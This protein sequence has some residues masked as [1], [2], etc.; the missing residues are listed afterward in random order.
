[1][2]SRDDFLQK[3]K[4]IIAKRAG[5]R[6]SN[7]TCHHITIGANSNPEKSTN[8]GV[9]SHI[10]AAA[11]GGPRYNPILTPVERVSI[12]NAIWLCQMCSVLIDKDPEIYTVEILKSWKLNIEKTSLEA[13]NTPGHT[14]IYCG[15]NESLCDD[16]IDPWSENFDAE[17]EK[18]ERRSSI[19][20]DITSLLAACRRM[21]SWDNRSELKLYSW[22]EEHSEDELG[23]E[24]IQTLE[25]IL[26]SVIEYLQIHIEMDRQLMNV[27]FDNYANESFLYLYIKIHPALTSREIADANRIDMKATRAV[28]EHMWK[29]GKIIPATLKDNPV[30]D[31]DSCRWMK[32][33]DSID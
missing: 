19:L 8:I 28:L 18:M 4:D 24:D 6:C 31:F 17:Y 33:Y 1:M 25:I 5:F 23:E 22:L 27:E 29:K 12:E 15:Y 11:Q 30:S 3:T 20:C 16:E 21:N 2:S 13:V 32:N 14:D 9:A 7:P 10:S 26:K